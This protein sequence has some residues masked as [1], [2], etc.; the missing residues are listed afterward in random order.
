MLTKLM[1]R[2]LQDDIAAGL[3]WKALKI[4]DAHK[5]KHQL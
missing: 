5:K 4:I 3:T 1:K 2:F